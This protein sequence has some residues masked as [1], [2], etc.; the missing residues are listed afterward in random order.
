[1]AE[2]CVQCQFKD[3][4][5]ADRDR[6]IVDLKKAGEL[7]EPNLAAALAHARAAGCPNCAATLQEFTQDLVAKTLAAISPDALRTMAIDRGV[8]PATI[9]VEVPRGGV[10]G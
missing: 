1:M 5:L 4:D 2:D 6:E 9:N 8:I 10:H 7:K 3:R